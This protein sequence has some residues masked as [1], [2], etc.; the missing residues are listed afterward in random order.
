MEDLKEM[1]SL[2][3]AKDL[4]SVSEVPDNKTLKQK[5]Q[6]R[7]QEVGDAKNDDMGLSICPA[8]FH[9]VPSFCVTIPL[10]YY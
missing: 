1:Q 6:R 3:E 8:A 7:S 2:V 10:L 4:W 5:V 9:F